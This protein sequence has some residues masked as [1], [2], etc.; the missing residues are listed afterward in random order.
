M[1]VERAITTTKNCLKYIFDVIDPLQCLERLRSAHLQLLRVSRQEMSGCLEALRQKLG[2]CCGVSNML[3]K[4]RG[5][6]KCHQ[7][8]SKSPS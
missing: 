3:S 8:L 1:Y 7:K 5:V 2:I 6:G 4:T